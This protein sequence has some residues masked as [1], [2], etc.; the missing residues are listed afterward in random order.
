MGAGRVVAVRL[1]EPAGDRAF[2]VAYDDVALDAEC[3]GLCPPF[4]DAAAPTPTTPA[5]PEP[6]ASEPTAVP[7]P[8]ETPVPEPTAP[9]V[10]TPVPPPA[11]TA[12]PTPA[13]DPAADE[14]TDSDEP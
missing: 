7:A 5:E 12:V 6:V 9:P 11:T 3:V 8:T 4:V 2:A 1:G 13:A 14:E 10:P